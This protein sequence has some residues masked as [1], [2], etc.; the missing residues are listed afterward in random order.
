MIIW[1]YFIFLLLL[2]FI[3]LRANSFILNI[4]CIFLFNCL[5]CLQ[6]YVIN[7]EF[8][9]L[10][11]LIIYLG[12]VLIFFIFILLSLNDIKNSAKNNNY[13]KPFFLTSIFT[14]ILMLIIYTFL[15]DYFLY[16]NIETND[17]FIYYLDH[18]LLSKQSVNL[19]NSS[20]VYTFD[21]SLF[22][23]LCSLLYTLFLVHVNIVAL[24]LF[25][26]LIISIYIIKQCK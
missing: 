15:P 16:N 2:L 19:Y 7:C 18:S 26:T 10:T 13:L 1:F 17:I 12:A 5:I 4:I 22:Q 14:I 25:I 3:F 11:I 21:I 8:L 24:F 6:F 23:L 9:S 20:S